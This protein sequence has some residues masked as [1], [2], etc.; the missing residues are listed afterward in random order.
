M[1]KKELAYDDP[2]AEISNH[3]E[4]NKIYLLDMAE[5][6]NELYKAAFEEVSRENKQLLEKL[7]ALN[8]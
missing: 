1:K 7:E 2:S 5:N 4:C 6:H 3:I 8:G